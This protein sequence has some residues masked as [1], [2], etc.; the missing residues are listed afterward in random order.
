MQQTQTGQR[1]TK[2]KGLYE[3]RSGKDQPK[4]QQAVCAKSPPFHAHW[5][6]ITLV[7]WFFLH[8][9]AAVMVAAVYFVKYVACAS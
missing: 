3:R 1:K 6:V 2:H 9:S 4:V 8:C 7:F 5:R